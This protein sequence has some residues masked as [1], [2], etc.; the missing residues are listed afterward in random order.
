M[1]ARRCAG[2]ILSF[3]TALVFSFISIATPV[4]A[5]AEKPQN[6][7]ELFNE[8]FYAAKYPDVVNVL[9]N[10]PEAL[11]KHFVEQGINEGR[12]CSA[13]LNVK[14]YRDFYSDINAAYGDDWDNVVK[15]YFDQGI[16]ENRKSFVSQEDL[17]IQNNIDNVNRSKNSSII[18]R[19][20]E[21]IAAAKTSENGYALDPSSG[22]IADNDGHALIPWS[23][24]Q[25]EGRIQDI[26]EL[27]E[28]CGKDL[29]LVRDE[30]NQIKFVGGKFSNV[31]VTDEESAVKA[32]DTMA[33]LYG[34]IDD[35]SYLKL[36]D[37]GK[38]SMGNPYFRFVPV[39]K[40]DGYTQD[41]YTVTISADKDGNVLGASNTL[42]NGLYSE[43]SIM[44]IEDGWGDGL[45][46]VLEDPENGYTKLFE[47]PKLIYDPE[48]MNY[49]WAMYYE[50]NGVVNEYLVETIEGKTL[51]MTRYYDAETFNNNPEQSFNRDYE[52]KNLNSPKEMTFIDYF[53]NPVKLPVAYEEGKGWYIVDPERHMVCVE[54]PGPKDNS[55]SK[56][57]IYDKH[58]F[59]DEY[60]EAVNAYINDGEPSEALEN[61]KV[62]V[63]SFTTIRSSFD[64]Y[65]KM[66][67]LPN[68]KTIY[69]NYK[70]EDTSDNASQTTLANMIVFT[71]NN[72]AGNADFAG[73]SHEFGH[74][75]VAN[76]GQNI[77]YQAA[78]GAINESYA[79][80]LGNLMKMIKKQEGSYAG[81]VDF[82]RWLIGEFLGNDTEHVIRDMSNP[83]NNGVGGTGSSPAPTQVNGQFFV[84][85]SGVYDAD[86]DNGGVHAN[87]SILSNIC[88]RMYNEVIAEKG[89]DGLGKPDQ[90]KYR[91][92]LQIWYDSVIYI[93][94]NTTYSDIK[95]YVLQSMKNHG[96]ST[97]QIKQTGDIFNDAKVDDYQPFKLGKVTSEIYDENDMAA[98]AKVGSNMSGQNELYN[99]MDSANDLRAAEYDLGIAIDEYKIA[100]LQGLTD[101]ELKPYEDQIAIARNSVELKNNNADE[102]YNSFVDSQTRLK[103][104]LDDKMARLEMQGAALK[105][106]TEEKNSNPALNRAYRALRRSF[107]TNLDDAS[108]IKDSL[109]DAVNEFSDEEKIMEVYDS[110]WN[111]SGEN[112]VKDNLTDDGS[113]TDDSQDSS[114]GYDDF[115][116]SYFNDL[117]GAFE[118]EDFDF[119]SLGD[120]DWFA[121]FDDDFWSEDFWGDDFFDDD[122]WNDDFW[123][124]DFWSDDFWDEDFFDD[125]FWSDDSS[126]DDWDYDSSDDDDWYDWS[127]LGDLL[128]D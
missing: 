87:N 14:M 114:L 111:F 122:F 99:Y 43:G 69:L 73:I 19:I 83:A 41:R 113:L 4:M 55:I 89:E 23:V 128:D 65:K 50:K 53:N 101:D 16:N 61:E 18:N 17:D 77:P 1:K 3:L 88:Y 104:M 36:N 57:V 79:D 124:D 125:D 62:L 120:V 60:F 24:V 70:Y 54:S 34:N 91:D 44:N 127:W 52:F 97:E 47:E 26:D 117:C 21:A 30:N 7:H 8:E 42:V 81:N 96:Y 11:Y 116:D 71:I 38:D 95:G 90:D 121:F 63:Q 67:M 110:V 105:K 5:A 12:T 56:S 31:K 92:L 46:S 37:T 32:L 64:E 51:S 20:D 29:I 75:V 109:D 68:P 84:D 2:K 98:A 123:S 59:S 102:Q 103:G 35:R 10:D 107:K 80:I 9:G 49:Y 76:Q 15:H 27:I 108:K 78:T 126:S 82:Q 13:A 118:I 74:A 115:W 33:N 72:N 106:V 100:K 66:G 6:L 85:D 58:Y 22:I 48:S 39:D 94:R 119:D 25:E 112:A 93:N 28:R 40:E 86:N 45:Q